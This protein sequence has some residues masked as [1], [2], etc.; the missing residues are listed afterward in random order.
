VYSR[1]N[2][3]TNDL[4]AAQQFALDNRERILAEYRS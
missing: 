4:A 2:T 1:W 3:Y